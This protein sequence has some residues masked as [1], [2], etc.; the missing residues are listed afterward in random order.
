M[1]DQSSKNGLA[2]RGLEG[3]SVGETE[4]A[5]VDGENGRLIYRGHD[6][7]ELAH[8][9]TFEQVAYLL[10]NGKLPDDDE[11]AEL[12]GTLV[13]GLNDARLR[14]RRD[15]EPR[16]GRPGDGRPAHRPLLVGR[17]AAQGRR[18]GRAGRPLG[19]RR[20]RRRSSPTTSGSARAWTS[21][22]PDASLGFVDN[23]LLKLTGEKPEASRARALDAYFTLAAEHGMNASTFTARVI[24]STESDLCSGLVG[25]IGALKGRLHGG[26]PSH[27]TSMLD[28]IGT[29]TTPSPGCAS[30]RGRRAAHGLRPPRLQDVRPARPGPRQGRRAARRRGRALRA[31][32]PR[33]G[34]RDPPARGVQAGPPAVHQRRVLRRRRPRRGRPAAGPVHARPSPRP[35][36]PAG[37][38]TSSSSSR[39]T[40][41]SGRR[42]TTSARCPPSALQHVPR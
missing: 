27:V 26:A 39:T 31:G 32:P 35:A 12:H 20:G 28:E 13:E 37:R 42:S 40:G 29:Q 15:A 22:A 18:R 30:D 19:A 34:D 21:V 3:V 4:I 9:A 24:V 38:P 25:A 2:V 36:P 11:L 16:A 5:L 6:A 1:S 10:W 17:V 8:E 23:Y 7:E 33:R 14:A 41:S